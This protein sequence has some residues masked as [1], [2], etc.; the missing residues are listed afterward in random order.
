M[1]RINA[2]RNIIQKYEDALAQTI[3]VGMD[4]TSIRIKIS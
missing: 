4:A 3:K 2:K 1:K